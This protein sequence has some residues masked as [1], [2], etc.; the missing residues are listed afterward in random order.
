MLDM[1]A[2]G[3]VTMMFNTTEGAQSIA[4]SKSIRQYALTS[5][6]PYF[7]TIA[8]ARAAVAAIRELQTHEL[9]VAPLQSYENPW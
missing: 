8:A 5:K 4:D 6:I 3:D 1:M 9:K 7:T 2:S